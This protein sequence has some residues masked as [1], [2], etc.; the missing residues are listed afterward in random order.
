MKASTIG[1]K[2]HNKIAIGVAVAAFWLVLWQLAARALG[3]EI[4]LVGP[5]Q[6]A[7]RLAELAVQPQFWQ[8]ILYSCGGIMAG[9]LLALAVGAVLAVVTSR[10]VLADALFKPLLQV[11]K[12]TPVASF[13]ILALVWI[14]SDRLATFAAFIMV[15]PMV[16]TNLSEGIAAVDTRLL[17]MAGV[18]GFS[19]WKKI[20]AVFLPSVLPYF[21][22]ALSA[23]IGIGWKAGIAA[24][25][26]GLPQISI[27]RALWGAK[28][29][30][31]T[32]D[33]FCW[34]AVIVL[35]SVLFERLMAALMRWVTRVYAGGQKEEKV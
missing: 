14:H 1:R 21:T 30:L 20:W 23:G 8:R 7:V 3:Q 29:Y 19:R 10:F 18:F 2:T 13:I 33:L 31:E 11:M 9:I 15:L 22:A 27:G 26:L 32:V 28:V 12:A 25:V 24:E 6:V 17:Q 16:W 34:T 35:L 5:V 4:L